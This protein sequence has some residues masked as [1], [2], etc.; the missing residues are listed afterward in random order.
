[1][2]VERKQ[3]KGERFTAVLN[4]SV[5]EFASECPPTPD[6]MTGGTIGGPFV[7]RWHGIYP[8]SRVP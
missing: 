6:G 5:L 4:D 7:M 2:G 1:M 3:V 8:V